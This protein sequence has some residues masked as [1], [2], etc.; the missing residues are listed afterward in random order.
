MLSATDKRVEQKLIHAN[1]SGPS[2]IK[3]MH[4]DKTL[5][6]EQKDKLIHDVLNGRWFSAPLTKW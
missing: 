1:Q 3:Q 6:S 2:I 5:T 4:Q